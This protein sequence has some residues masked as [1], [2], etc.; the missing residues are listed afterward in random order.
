MG[1]YQMQ[2]IRATTS[3]SIEEYVVRTLYTD[4]GQ[5][6]RLGGSSRLF[7]IIFIII[8]IIIMFFETISELIRLFN[9]SRRSHKVTCIHHWPLQPFSLDQWL[10]A[11]TT[12]ILFVF[13]FDVWPGA[14]TLPTRLR[15][16]HQE[17]IIKNVSIFVRDIC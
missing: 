15:R 1:A 6:N 11:R 9:M 13:C 17:N 10:V 5:Y 14:R 2:D 8:T 4:W 12:E 7:F 3:S 16:L